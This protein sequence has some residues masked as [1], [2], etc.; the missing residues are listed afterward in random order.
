MVFA[1]KPCNYLFLVSRE[2]DVLPLLTVNIKDRQVLIMSNCK[3]G[4]HIRKPR[5]EMSKVSNFLMNNSSQFVSN[6]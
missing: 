6:S 1:S 2:T 3:M 4:L 5:V